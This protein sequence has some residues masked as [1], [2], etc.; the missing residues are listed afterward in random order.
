ME[1]GVLK[2]EAYNHYKEQKHLEDVQNTLNFDDKLFN[3]GKSMLAFHPE[4]RMPID[5][6]LKVVLEFYKRKIDEA[7]DP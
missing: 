7:N 5:R 2:K 3:I 1:T 6:A 4:E